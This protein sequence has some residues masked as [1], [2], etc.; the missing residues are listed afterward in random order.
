[1]SKAMRFMTF[2]IEQYSGIK[3]MSGKD[4]YHLFKETGVLTYI[5]ECAEALHTLGIP[6]L[7]ADVDGYIGT[8]KTSYEGH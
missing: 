1:M 3:G 4:V 5:Y 8:C 7:I 2:F 6:Y